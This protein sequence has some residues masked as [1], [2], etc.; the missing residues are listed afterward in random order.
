VLVLF[1]TVKRFYLLEP[2]LG[3]GNITGNPLLGLGVVLQEVS[4]FPKP[5]NLLDPSSSSLYSI[6]RTLV[7]CSIVSLPS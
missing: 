6:S 7:D 4:F 1:T 2:D 5:I 3:I